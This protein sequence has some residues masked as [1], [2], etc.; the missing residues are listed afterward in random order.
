ML[1]E[2]D[3]EHFNPSVR[4]IEF[5]KTGQNCGFHLTRGKWDPYP[6][7][8]RV[9]DGSVAHNAGLKAGDCLLEVNGD[10][11]V[12]RRISEIA[13]LVKSK[14]GQ[15][16]LLIW[17]AG[18]DA[19]CTPEALCCGPITS[20]FQ[21]LSACMSTI[22]AFL[23]CPV[24]L[25][26]I[27][28][29]TYQCDNGHLICIRCRAKSERCPVC[30]H[31]LARGR[32]LLSDQVYH[33]I[34]DAFNLRDENDESKI[35]K[36]QQ[37][38]KPK[39]KNKS[40]PNIKVIQCHTSKLLAKVIGKASSVENLTSNSKLLTPNTNCS[41]LKAKS[42]STNEIFH[43]EVSNVSRTGSISRLSRRNETT[44]NDSLTNISD[45]NNRPTSFYG[46]FEYL[47]RDDE[48]VTF[49][50][51]FQSTCPVIIKG[52]NVINHFQTDHSGPLI[53][54]FGSHIKLHLNK[55][56]SENCFVINNSGTTFFVNTISNISNVDKNSSSLGDVLIWSW[57]SKTDQ[58]C[59]HFDIEIDL[60][61]NASSQSVFRTRIPILPLNSV[62]S[63]DV[64]QFKKGVFL[65]SKILE[66]LPPR[67]L[68]LNVDIVSSEANNLDL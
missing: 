14:S 3:E 61:D 7:V 35:A 60:V 31:R 62:S 44:I 42:L 57:H 1:A 26:T 59:D 47:N 40:I 56:E 64:R 21:K 55:L 30:R 9:D 53:Q 36:I 48:P 28:P 12:G 19:Q 45:F 41:T 17:N 22:L 10:D 46:S 54:Y 37:I 15:V 65:G 68:I 33:A 6:W 58:S 8:S 51:P 34:V 24:C 25:D 20:N 38:F 27:S 49:H 32:S 4:V 29:P 67:D 50:C 18:V 66:I 52:H 2:S 63:Q 5:E 16:S 23:E 39:I 11:I 43:A 13:D